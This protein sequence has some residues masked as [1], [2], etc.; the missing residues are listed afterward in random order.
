MSYTWQFGSLLPYIEVLLRGLLTT[1]LLTL[2]VC[3]LGTLLGLVLALVEGSS[4]PIAVFVSR[5]FVEVVRGV[6]A[7]VWLLWFYYC[8]PVLFDVRLESFPTAVIALSIG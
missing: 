1:S 2:A 3:L 4:V 6:P 7:L 5:R 8:L